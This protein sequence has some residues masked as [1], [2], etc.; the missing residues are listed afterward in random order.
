MLST[1]LPTFR[2]DKDALETRQS[3]MQ[4][5]G[6]SFKL[7]E[8]IDE[9]RFD[10]IASNHDIVFLGIGARQSRSI[11]IP[12][13]G[14]PQVTDALSFLAEFNQGMNSNQLQNQRVIVI[15]GGD[16][17]MDCARAATRVGA[18]QVT[19]T[20]R[21]SSEDM[22]ASEEERALTRADG[23][24]LE[25]NHKPVEILGTDCV[26]SVQ[27]DV[28]GRAQAIECDTVILAIGQQG[29]HTGAGH[30][31]SGLRTGMARPLR[32]ANREWPGD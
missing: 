31:R 18:R 10:Q 25:F 27:F 8:E 26:T 14:L 2:F 19:I 4:K 29:V 21:S 20:Y 32:S 15:G 3:W 22:R 16:S 6:V 1:G 7:G 24:E 23:A 17:A 9:E 13:E 11:N 30:G 12:G 5:N 28:E